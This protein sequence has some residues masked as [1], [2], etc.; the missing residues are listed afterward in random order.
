MIRT[1]CVVLLVLT[2]IGCSKEPDEASQAA[3][4]PTAGDAQLTF[5]DQTWQLHVRGDCGP[6]EDGTYR[7]WAFSLDANGEP[8]PDAP[9]LLALSEGDWSVIDFSTG[10]GDEIHRVYREGDEKFGFTD[11]KLEFAGELGAGL[12]EKAEIRIV[13]P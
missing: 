3:T 10:D 8:I 13:C 4:S 12:S 1:F 6:G 11:G 9:H 2:A 7:T 5:R